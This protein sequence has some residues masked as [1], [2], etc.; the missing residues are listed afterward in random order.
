M[1]KTLTAYNWQDPMF[2]NN[3]LTEEERMIRDTAHDYCQNKLL[4][5]VLKANRD[6]VFDI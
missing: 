1:S 6:E 4:P 3:Q 2:L 5:R